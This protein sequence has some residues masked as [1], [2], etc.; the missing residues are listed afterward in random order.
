MYT[1]W[2]RVISGIKNVDAIQKGP[3]EQNGIVPDDLR[4]RIVSMRVA[5]DIK[6][7]D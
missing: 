7:T 4:D 3:K 6:P 1:A 5:A 2:G